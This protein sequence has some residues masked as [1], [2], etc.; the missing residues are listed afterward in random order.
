MSFTI[1]N[2]VLVSVVRIPRVGV[3]VWHFV[4]IIPKRPDN[5]EHQL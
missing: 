1:N 2:T 3:D 4:A 5:L